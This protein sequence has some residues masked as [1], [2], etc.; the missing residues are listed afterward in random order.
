VGARHLDPLERAAL[1]SSRVAL[2]PTEQVDG[3]WTASLEGAAR[4]AGAY[5]HLDLDVMDPAEGPANRFAE[6]DGL[7]REQ[8]ERVIGRVAARLPIEAAALTAYEPAAD[9]SSRAGEAAME[10]CLALAAAVAV[11]QTNNGRAGS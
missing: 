5:L 11:S 4:A 1:E 3:N 2:V 9:P 8:I 7:S 10:L 6:P